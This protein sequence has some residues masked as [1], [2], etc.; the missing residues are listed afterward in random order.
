MAA[1]QTELDRCLMIYLV[2][3]GASRGER[4]PRQLIGNRH[5]APFCEFRTTI[6][7]IA[8]CAAY[9][10][11]TLFWIVGAIPKANADACSVWIGKLNAHVAMEKRLEAQLKA[12]GDCSYVPKL[13]TA[14]WKGRAMSDAL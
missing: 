12:S 11:L 8:H 3:E 10:T 5:A 7:G 13:M 2:S 9:A 1:I 14:F 6:R 4:E